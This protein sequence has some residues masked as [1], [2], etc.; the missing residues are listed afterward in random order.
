MLGADP[1]GPACRTSDG[2]KTYGPI[3]RALADAI[4][5]CPALLND[6]L[7][8]EA[9]EGWHVL[10]HAGSDGED[11]LIIATRRYG[12]DQQRCRS[13]LGAPISGGAAMMRVIKLRRRRAR[14][15]LRRQRKILRAITHKGITKDEAVRRLGLRDYAE[16][17]V[18]LGAFGVPL[19]RLPDAD[20]ARIVDGF[21]KLWRN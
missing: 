2:D 6:A 17:L 7:F 12:A 14:R 15:R 1:S 10:Q 8:A 20:I 21:L 5:A 11:D 4:L 18:V 9:V 19:P 13:G 3:F 16:L